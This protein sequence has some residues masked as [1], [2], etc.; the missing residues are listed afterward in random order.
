MRLIFITVTC[1]TW[2]AATILLTVTGPGRHNSA[3]IAAAAVLGLPALWR[4]RHTVAHLFGRPP[5]LK[6]TQVKR[7]V[8]A[9]L[10]QM[11]RKQYYPATSDITSVSFHVWVVPSWYRKL[12]YRIRRRVTKDRGKMPLWLRPRLKRV[13]MYRFEHLN[14]SG[15]TFRKAIGLVGRCIAMNEGGQARIL[16]L[17][18]GRF[19]AALK[20]G[21]EAWKFTDE[22]V[23]QNLTYAQAERLA[24]SYGQVAALVIREHSG[25]AIGCVTL[26]LPPNCGFRLLRSEGGHRKVRKQALPLL[27][28]L[29]ETRNQVATILTNKPDTD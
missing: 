8:Q 13:S 19:Q 9:S 22:E 17:D 28:L 12:P 23:S 7:T 21:P 4:L 14:S 26:D 1:A 15:I 18:R 27:D 16:E 5:A 24:E 3:R 2:L 29:T 11:Y 20:A 10:V 6:R 25:E